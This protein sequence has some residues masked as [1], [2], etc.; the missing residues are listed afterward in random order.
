MSAIGGISGTVASGPNPSLV[1][2]A[3]PWDN[4]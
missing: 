1:R 3:L 2:A 4:M